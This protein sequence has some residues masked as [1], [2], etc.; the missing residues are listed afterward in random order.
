MGSSQFQGKPAIFILASEFVD[1]TESTGS[2]ISERL[3]DFSYVKT[4]SSLSLSFKSGDT[5]NGL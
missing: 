4:S 1:G 2:K 3:P 5:I